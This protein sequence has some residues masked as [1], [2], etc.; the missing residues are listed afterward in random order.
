MDAEGEGEAILKG[1]RSS[2]HFVS[3]ANQTVESGNEKSFELIESIA[4]CGPVVAAE[5]VCGGRV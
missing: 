3:R 5:R 2:S 1:P 4:T